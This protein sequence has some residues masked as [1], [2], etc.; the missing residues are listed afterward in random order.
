MISPIQPWVAERTGLNQRL[1]AETLRIWQLKQV[2]KAMEYTISHSKFYAQRL[3]G[4][5]ID[6]ILSIEYMNTIPFTWPE[7]VI[8]D[9]KSFICV[10][11]R[12]I[13]RVI[14]L[15]TSGSQGMPKR[16]YFTE[17]DLERTVD[18]FAYGMSTMV[19]RGQ[20]VLIL[21]SGQ[22]QY[23]IGDLLQKG[24]ARIGVKS[25]VHGHVRDVQQALESA[26]DA[27]CL[28]GVPEEIIYMCRS[29]NKLRPKS[30]LLSADYVPESVI[31]GIE[32][33]WKCKVFTHYGMTETCFGCGVQC[34][35]GSGYHLRDCHLLVEIVDP[36]TGMQVP[37]GQY[38]EVTITTFA[39][40]AMPLIRYRTGDIARMQTENCTC[41][42]IIP[43]LDKVTG[44]YA[45]IVSLCNGD[46][47][48]IHELDEIMFA[49][50]EVR[51]FRAEFVNREGRKILCL[52]VDSKPGLEYK[53]LFEYLRSSL[54]ADIELQ[55]QYAKVGPF[56]GTE[57]RRILLE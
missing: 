50:P 2:R 9:P 27:D 38:G 44:R 17:G 20:K 57:K 1:T 48:S 23:S 43:C 45:N 7:D 26:R 56:A 13:S 55:I 40:E 16:I 54:R 51:N 4:I 22:T 11:Q 3:R 19:E 35:A 28:V 21:M 6:D 47:L 29:D 46:E 24:L 37:P 31:K 34:D 18:F 15:S 12:D 42:G 53:K 8:R 36:K 39:Y 32:D 10:P 30:V 33:A 14:T 25:E 52:T 49:V 5:N 41:G